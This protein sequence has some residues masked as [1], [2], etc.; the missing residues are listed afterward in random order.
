LWHISCIPDSQGK[1]FPL[2]RE[3]TAAL[4]AHHEVPPGL[5]CGGVGKRVRTM[6]VNTSPNASVSISWQAIALMAVA[7]ALVVVVRATGPS[8]LNQV[9][10][11][12]QAAYV[13]DILAN[14]H[15]IVQFDQQGRVA[16]KP[17]LYN[18]L[19]ASLIRVRGKPSEFILKFPSV[20]AALGTLIVT[21]L[22]AGL[23]LG[24]WTALAAALILASGHHFFK[25][26]YLARTDMLLC[27]W[28]IL[29]LY[30]FERSRADGGPSIWNLLFWIIQ[31][32][33]TL[34]KG[35]PG[36]ALVHVYVL[37]RLALE[38][39][40][41]GYLRLGAWWG[42]PLWT[43]LSLAWFLPALQQGGEPFVERVLKGE[44]LFRLWGTGPRAGELQPFYAFFPWF[45]ARFLPWSLLATIA[46]LRRGKSCPLR[47]QSPL[48][49]P[50]LWLGS[51]MILLSLIP[52]KR[53]DWLM[54]VYPA[55]AILAAHLFR[56]ISNPPEGPP[57][58]V[59][60]CTRL[61]FLLVAALMASAGV[62]FLSI[63]ALS[64]IHPPATA[65]LGTIAWQASPW[66]AFAAGALLL[67]GGGAAWTGM[68][69]LMPRLALG[70]F[71]TGL[72]ALN[73]IYYHVV[74]TPAVTL[75][76]D[77]LQQFMT[78]VRETIPPGEKVLFGT[79]RTPTQFFLLSNQLYADSENIIRSVSRGRPFWLVMRLREL[80]YLER[81]RGVSFDIVLVSN[82]LE[83][84]EARLALAR[85]P[86]REHSVRP[87]QHQE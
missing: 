39:D 69:R 50:A 49:P 7:V 43:A 16:T 11:P 47:T 36:P 29:S 17:P 60:R 78:Q 85:W 1:F 30:A 31:A 15:Y 44:I 65:L 68:R 64:S 5:L 27:F 34:T 3:Q 8:D 67:W 24:P 72:L 79:T 23:W 52:S 28:I 20:L 35:P 82:Y 46:L 66:I 57:E 86:S 83:Y 59:I 54:P 12:L 19:A 70:G 81:G 40:L 21:F 22:L 42:I 71:L 45:V 48:M 41:R 9:D 63:F 13:A 75:D 6:A 53:A 51:M 62:L 37:G 10:Q 61:L 80:Q 56:Q 87:G 77:E 55:G 25:M 32:M 26:A 74:A 58:R 33:A 73:L 18:W 14:G 38:R 84:D 4:P 2:C 76:G